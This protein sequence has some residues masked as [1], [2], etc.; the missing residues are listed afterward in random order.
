MVPGAPN[1]LTA[2]I[3]EDLGFEAVY[4]TGAGVTNMYLGLPDIG[5]I[6]VTELAD[7]VA[8]IREAVRIPVIVDADT[9]FGNPINVIRTVKLLERAGANA[10]QLEDQI[11]PKRCGHFDGKQVVSQEEMLQRLRAALDARSSDD[12]LIIARTDARAVLGFE[13][14]LERAA[15]F[16]E[17]GADLV[18]VEAPES[19]EE[20]RE[21]PRRVPGL[22]VINMVIGG[23]T[24]L[25]D[26][27]QLKELGYA[28]V[29]YANTAL[30]AAI[31][32]MQRVLRELKEQGTIGDVAGL[33]APFAERQRLVNK[34]YYDELE[35][36]YAQG[37]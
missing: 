9:G 24:P 37:G 10:I 4:V 6:S 35:R 31:H 17:A 11:F 25:L 34:P 29:L 13:A 30:Q 14:A 12:L 36:R 5:L 7:H 2:R 32:G 21:I 26:L 3:I 16:V 8:R 22:H 15:A 18:F 33:I 23:R 27:A 1:A 28:L 20:I 19:L